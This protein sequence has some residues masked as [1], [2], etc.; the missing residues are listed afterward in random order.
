MR[1]AGF[2]DTTLSFFKKLAKNQNRAWFAA[3]KS[4]Y[5]EGWHAPMAALP[6]E[7]REALDD[8]SPHIELGEPTSARAG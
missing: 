2:A 1:C 8:A 6:A 4:E 5:D 3:H 7:A